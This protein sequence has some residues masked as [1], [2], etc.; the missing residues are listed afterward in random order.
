MH[1]PQPSHQ[2][3]PYHS[4]SLSPLHRVG[5]R[6]LHSLPVEHGVGCVWPG[7]GGKPTAPISAKARCTP[8]PSPDRGGWLDHVTR[9]QQNSFREKGFEALLDSSSQARERLGAPPVLPPLG[10]FTP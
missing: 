10:P 2:S 4:Q 1:R 6:L 8:P 3:V 5:L 7:V 9:R